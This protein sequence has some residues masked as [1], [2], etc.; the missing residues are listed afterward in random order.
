MSQ[1][2][3][4]G[5]LHDFLEILVSQYSPEPDRA[6]RFGSGRSGYAEH[7]FGLP[8]VS[9]FASQILNPCD[10]PPLKAGSSS[11]PAHQAA[12]YQDQEHQAAKAQGEPASSASR[13]LGRRLAHGVAAL[14]L[15]FHLVRCR[16]ST[17]E[18][19]V[20]RDGGVN[21]A[22]RRSVGPSD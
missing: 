22:G 3:G 9:D 1:K 2:R 11:F 20:G 17:I 6:W 4:K 18:I 8:V 10:G 7:S 14:S 5:D 16:N 21:F 15:G 13:L 19:V 12:H